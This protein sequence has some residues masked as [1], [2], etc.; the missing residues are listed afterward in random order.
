MKIVESLECD[1]TFLEMDWIERPMS[2]SAYWIEVGL[3]K[4]IFTEKSH[5]W[6]S[7]MAKTT[8]GRTSI[9]S[10]TDF[11]FIWR[12]GEQLIGSRPDFSRWFTEPDSVIGGRVHFVT[13]S[14]VV[15]SNTQGEL[16]RWRQI[17]ITLWL[18]HL[19][20]LMNISDSKTC[21]RV[22]YAKTD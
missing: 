15:C 8:I 3:I 20:L 2:E 6:G 14:W 13:T 22:R 19:R 10:K 11:L 17:L 16:A 21:F 4:I 5:M 12:S 7:M 18:A 9:L 1:L